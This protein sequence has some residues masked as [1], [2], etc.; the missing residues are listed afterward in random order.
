MYY[1][2]H[3][4]GI[5]IGCTTKHPEERAKQQGYIDY[6]ILEEHFDIYVASDRELELQK[7]YNYP[8][9]DTPFYK[10]YQLTL[11]GKTSKGGKTSGN[12]LK[13]LGIGAMSFKV[14]SE[15]GKIGGKISANITMASG[16]W[17]QYQTKEYKSLAGKKGGKVSMSIEKTCPYCNRC[18]KGPSYYVHE[19]VCKLKIK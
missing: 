15:A 3:I 11:S 9:D 17:D 4:P 18:I 7:K 5:K 19:K 6:E 12:K 16:R 10:T 1:I 14:R 8:V 2:Y 13:E